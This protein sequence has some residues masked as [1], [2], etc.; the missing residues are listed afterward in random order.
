M[1][2]SKDT[3][4]LIRDRANIVDII[5][6]YVPDLKKRGNNYIGLCPFH[7]E[8]T[9]SF[10]VS[11]EKGIFY[12]FG[13][14][15]GGNI[16]SFIQKIEGMN[17]PESVRH[18]AD[19]L[20][21]E[22]REVNNERSEASLLFE[23]NAAASALFYRI[24]KSPEGKAGYDY[25][26][27][28][29]VNDESIE[30][31]RLGYIPDKWGIL[32]DHLKKMGFNPEKALSI[33]LISS[34]NKDGREHYYDRFRG[35]VI[36]P[37]INRNNRIIA[38]GGRVIDDGSPKYLN[39][40]ESEIFHKRQELYGFNMARD[41]ISEVKRAII[42]EGYLDVI[43]C[44]QAGI[45]NVVAPLGTSLTKE[46]LTL[47]SRYCTEIIILFDADS[48][49]INAALKSLSLGDMVNT[50]LRVA[51][52]PEGD[53]FDFVT[54]RSAREFMAVI[55]SAMKP[56]EFRI[57][58]MYQEMRHGDPI[59]LLNHLFEIISDLDMESERSIYL[60]KISS[61]L[62]LDERAVRTDFT[63][64]QQKKKPIYKTTSERQNT[65][66]QD[67]LT[68][69]YRQLIKLL[70]HYPD[71][72]EKAVIDFSVDEIKDPVSRSIFRSITDI[73]YSQPGYS[74][75]RLF[76]Y[77]TEGDEFTFLQ[78]IMAE[79]PSLEDSKAAYTEIYLTMK[80]YQID[81]KMNL[82]AEKIKNSPS[83]A[84]DYLTEFEILRRE[85]EKL[86]SF[87]YNRGPRH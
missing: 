3:I 73:H 85:K 83:S 77:F 32:T 49:G 55:D 36:F 47:L 7:R 61:L 51:L 79:T 63:S 6:R 53:P 58:R 54:S 78:K 80:I 4:E 64:F 20:G 17:F 42:V 45:K 8:K 26:L 22:I 86:S 31:F 14:H 19:I 39:S 12:C 25:L 15:A 46:H 65:D 21:I 57:N 5:L 34:S 62:K 52:L 60:G 70:C 40:P 16:F 68:R 66:V 81:S 69:S 56:V 72:I 1:Q 24:I 74:F 23:M 50:E 18:L 28:R 76:D 75:S 9:P 11:P 38:F 30:R 13:C 84:G 10:T 48:A 71:L 33:G 37:I 29:G 82:L 67:F 43:G 59:I 35:R 87:V 41:H 27:R 2:L 44:H